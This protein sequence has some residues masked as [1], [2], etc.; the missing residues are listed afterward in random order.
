M[1]L[2]Q[3]DTVTTLV[4]IAW[5]LKVLR[6]GVNNKKNPPV[7]TR[8]INKKRNQFPPKTKT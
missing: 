2:Q 7:L 5:C 3:S 1:N 4:S 6:E 8:D